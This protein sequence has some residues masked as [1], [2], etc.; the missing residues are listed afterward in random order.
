MGVLGPNT[1]HGH[2]FDFIRKL[3]ANPNSLNVLGNGNQKKAYVDVDDVINA[4]IQTKSKNFDVFNLGRSDFS[5]VRDSVKWL[6]EELEINPIIQ[7][8][9]NDRGWVGDNPHLYL[10]ITKLNETGWR[11]TRTIE[12]SVKRTVRWIAENPSRLELNHE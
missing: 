2:L 6:C 8:E 3:R 1:S 7:Y 12:E 4:L 11:P 9:E 5:T 10:D